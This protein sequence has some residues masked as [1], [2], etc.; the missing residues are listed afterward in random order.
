MSGRRTPRVSILLATHGSDAFI[1]RQLSSI[2]QQSIWSEAELI[3]VAND[4]SAA[5]QAAMAQF[6]TAWKGRVQLFTTRRE[7]LYASWN[8]GIN[9]AKADLLT[10]ANVDDLRTP[11]ALEAQIA[12]LQASPDALFCYGSYVMVK[13][14]GLTTGR[15][16]TPPE[17]DALEFTRSMHAGPF[18]AWRKVVGGSKVY[19]DEQFRSGGDFDFVI[20]LSCLGRGVRAKELLGSYYDAGSGLSTGSAL[21]PIERTVIELRYGIYDKVDYGYL[22]EASRY[23]IAHLRWGGRWHQVDV[24]VPEYDSW[25]SERRRKWFRRGIARYRQAQTWQLPLRAAGTVVAGLKNLGRSVR[26]GPGAAK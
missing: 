26:R 7:T 12:M 23:N 15:L 10:I 4:P 3:L 11:T 18:F 2:A 9:A 1:T 19:F 21:Q 17:F 5:E 24:L 8:R 16:V 20:R 6:R 25:M 22:P 14:F 13:E